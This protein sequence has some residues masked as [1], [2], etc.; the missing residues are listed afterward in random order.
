MRRRISLALYSL[1]CGR[2]EVFAIKVYSSRKATGK[3]FSLSP[4]RARGKP[5]LKPSSA[6]QVSGFSH[7]ERLQKRHKG[8]ATS[9]FP[10]RR[11]RNLEIG[12]PGSLLL[13]SRCFSGGPDLRGKQTTHPGERALSSRPPRE[14][15]VRQ[16]PVLTAGAF[17]AGN[18]EASPPA[19]S[20]PDPQ[21]T[22]LLI[23][24]PLSPGLNFP[25]FIPTHTPGHS[26]KRRG[27]GPSQTSGPTHNHCG[28]STKLTLTISRAFFL[29]SS[30]YPLNRQ[31]I[32]SKQQIDLFSVL[33][34]K[35]P[36]SMRAQA[37]CLDLPPEHLH[38]SLRRGRTLPCHRGEAEG[39]LPSRAF[40]LDRKSVV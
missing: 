1:G 8:K 33:A 35:I 39:T 30:N 40:L 34:V 16:R 21:E 9:S 28:Q 23:R 19:G 5:K 12:S 7:L 4:G 27:R 24:L 29:E 25:S 36:G 13:H 18:R 10:S 6:S 17:Q 14:A 37:C 15:A 26:T 3:R 20:G 22:F 38:A 11:G 31:G 2:E 32:F